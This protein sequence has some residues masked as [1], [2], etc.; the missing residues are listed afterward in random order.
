MDLRK[1]PRRDDRSR[2]WKE[3]T[4][5]TSE[6]ENRIKVFDFSSVLDSRTRILLPK[7]SA[8]APARTRTRNSYIMR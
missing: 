1:F 8:R 3:E 2:T 6:E 4:R 7:R 5:K